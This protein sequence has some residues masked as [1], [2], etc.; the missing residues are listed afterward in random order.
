VSRRAPPSSSPWLLCGARSWPGG[1]GVDLMIRDGRVEVAADESVTAETVVDADGRFVLPGLVN[2]HDQLDVS[3]LPPLGAPPHRDLYEWGRV[4]AAQ[5]ESE[6]IRHAMSVALPDRLFLGGLRNLFAGV[7]AT[8]HHG[9]DHR[10]FGSPV[11]PL[12]VQR[13]YGF[14]HSPGLSPDIRKRYRSTDRRIPWFVRAA[15]GGAEAP[16]GE[17]RALADANVLRENTVIVGGSALSRE[18]VVEIAAAK[19]SLVWCPEVDMRLYH[20]TAPVSALLS[21][22]VRLGLG[23]DGSP[24]GG[25]DLLS[26]LASASA[27]GLLG[28]EALID[29][30]TRGSGQV[31]RLPVGGIAA[32]DVADLVVVDSV[33]DLL[34]GRRTALSL[35]V[36]AGRPVLGVAELMRAAP[37]SSAVWIDGAERRLAGPIAR[38]ARS[39]LAGERRISRPRWLDGLRLG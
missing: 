8:V 21:H 17:I 9:P 11:F 27:A 24:A 26:A 15:A 22:G 5:S 32:G 14:A 16:R 13:R 25:R 1:R 12:R 39:L 38:R 10:A 4:A 19:A 29:V 23:S 2:A 35:V 33:D 6:A 34:R 3:L 20:A 18:E 36:V 28:D 7:T 31:A 30:A 37:E